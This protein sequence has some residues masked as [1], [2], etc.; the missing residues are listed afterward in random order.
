[1]I[2]LES[3]ASAGR[4]QLPILERFCPPD[5]LPQGKPFYHVKET[6]SRVS[7]RLFIYTSLYSSS[8]SENREPAAV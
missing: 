8:S 6:F 2:S 4:I 5:P 3:R 7:S 1:M